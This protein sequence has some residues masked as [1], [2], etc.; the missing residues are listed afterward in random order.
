LFIDGADGKEK[1]SPAN[2][3][4]NLFPILLRDLPQTYTDMI[5]DQLVD[6]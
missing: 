3:V 2:T 1:Y 6:E 4:Q 5:V